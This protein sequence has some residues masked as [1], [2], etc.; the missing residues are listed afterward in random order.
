MTE[1][2]KSFGH[3]NYLWNQSRFHNKWRVAWTWLIEFIFS[4]YGWL[5]FEVKAIRS[6]NALLIKFP[7]SNGQIFLKPENQDKPNHMYF[8]APG[9]V[10]RLLLVCC[11][12]VRL[13]FTSVPAPL[14][15]LNALNT[16]DLNYPG[17]QTTGLCDDLVTDLHYLEQERGVCVLGFFWVHCLT[18]RIVLPT[19]WFGK[20]F[21]SEP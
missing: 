3:Y 17:D 12:C 5:C 1:K 6:L 9:R 14:W 11:L 15:I 21:R 8:R 4:A 19:L 13:P 10:L 18:K 20:F 2:G 7:P 16:P